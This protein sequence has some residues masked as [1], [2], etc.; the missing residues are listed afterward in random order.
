MAS[1]LHMCPE[2]TVLQVCAKISGER[3]MNLPSRAEL[4]FIPL[5]FI[6]VNIQEREKGI[7]KSLTQNNKLPALFLTL[8]LLNASRNFTNLIPRRSCRFVPE[9]QNYLLN[10]DPYVDYRAVNLQAFCRPLRASSAS[11]TSTRVTLRQYGEL[12][13]HCTC[14]FTKPDSG[15][16]NPQYRLVEG[17]KEQGCGGLLCDYK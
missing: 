8:H 4:G 3:R 2:S 7:R 9:L 14:S 10:N 6:I 11:C 5:S 16:P 13:Q 15:T 12:E 17:W 1:L